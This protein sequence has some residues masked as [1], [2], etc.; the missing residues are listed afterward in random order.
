MLKIIV[1]KSKEVKTGRGLAESSKEAYGSK[2]SVLTMT[3]MMMVLSG[4]AV[5]QLVG[6]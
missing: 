4:M 3:N 2:R 1:P 6:W 5:E